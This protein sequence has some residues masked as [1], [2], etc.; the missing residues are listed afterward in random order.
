MAPNR[1][2]RASQQPPPQ[3]S[4]YETDAPPAVEVPRP[5]PRSNEELNFK[6]LSRIYPDLVTIEHVTPYAVLY[7]YKLET[8]QWEKLG[9]EGTLFI[10]RLTPSPI[11][12]ERFCAIIHNRRGLDNFYQELTNSEEMEVSDPYVIMHGEDVFGI[13]IFA[14]PP[15]AST[16]NCR[17]ETAAKMMEYAGKAKASREALQPTSTAGEDVEDAEDASAS[18][19]AMGRQLSLRELFGQ[20][21]EQDAGFTIHNHNSQPAAAQSDVLGQLFMRAKQH[22]TGLG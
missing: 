10:C 13:W 17:V 2:A 8:Q 19:A 18:S 3:A 11:G 12:A 22:H 20:Q 4:D 16:A 14:D 9:I 15:P 5:P 21:R 7:S 6:V 1:K